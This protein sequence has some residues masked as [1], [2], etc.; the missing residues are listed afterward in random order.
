M[1]KTIVTLTGPSASGKST[2]ERM[3]RDK[4]GYAV[5]KGTTTRPPRAEELTDGSLYIFVDDDEYNRLLKERQFVEYVTI[6]NYRYGIT[7]EAMDEAFEESNTIVMIL[8]PPALAQTRNYYRGD[9]DTLIVSFFI[10]TPRDVRMRRIVNR[11]IETITHILEEDGVDIP[12]EVTKC[13]ELTASRIRYTDEVES[14]WIKE[15]LYH[16]IIKS[17]GLGTEDHAINTIERVLAKAEADVRWFT[18]DPRDY[19]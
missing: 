14:N 15:S 1:I 2:L 7:K 18:A 10:N 8:N 4:F 6:N 19:K 9:P 12:N 11:H 3:L 17:F 16:D 5:A 13:C